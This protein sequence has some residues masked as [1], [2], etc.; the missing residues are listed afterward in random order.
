MLARL[1]LNVGYPARP[2]LGMNGECR[3]VWEGPTLAGPWVVHLP[4]GIAFW[5]L[6]HRMLRGYAALWCRLAGT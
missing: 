3:V 2:L 6:V 1:V 5:L 4:G